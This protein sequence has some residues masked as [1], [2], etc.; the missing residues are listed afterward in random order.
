M[1]LPG[2][3]CI[4]SLDPAVEKLRT[5]ASG[6]AAPE[7]SLKGTAHMQQQQTQNNADS[8]TANRSERT[9]VDSI[10]SELSAMRDEL[11][12]IAHDVRMKS[13]GASAEVQDRRRVIER[14]IK[15]FSAEISVAADE[16]RQDLK[17]TGEA[18]RMRLHELANQLALPS[19]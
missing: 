3:K 4:R 7:S 11:E 19:S 13:K 17:E 14:E 16:T 9:V 1:R 18:L 12:R 15:R 5:A 2:S 10:S 8:S 6:P